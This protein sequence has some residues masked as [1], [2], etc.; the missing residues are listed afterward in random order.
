MNRF[1]PLALAALFVSNAIAQVEQTTQMTQMVTKSAADTTGKIWTTGGLVSLNFNQIQLINWTGGGVSS[2]S[3][4]G[5]F[6]AFA[7][8]KKG[9]YSWDNSVAITYGLMAQEGKRTFKTDDRFELNSKY[10]VEL[11]KSLYF[12]TLFQFR[13]QFA[14]GFKTIDDTVAISTF[15]APAYVLL[16][17]GFDYKPNESFSLFVSP[18]MARLIIVMDQDL[19]DG[20]AFGVEAAVRDTAGVI[21]TPGENTDFQFGGYLN[22][23]Y[24][25]DIAKNVSFYTRLELFSNYLREPQNVDVNWET[26]WTFKVN[27]FLSANL[28]TILIYDHDIDIVRTEDNVVK[29]GPTTQF[30]ESFGLGLTL[31]F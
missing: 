29:S 17:L 15:L 26:M 27:D 14:E 9:K 30:K 31:K 23:Q 11:K 13:T 22:A 12:S 20:G 10:G 25:K 18:A 21:I 8:R 3:G 7:N 16:G 2:I 4:V 24:K 6:N 19:A 1:I 28:N 5:I